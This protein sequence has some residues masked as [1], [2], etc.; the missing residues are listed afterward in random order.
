MRKTCAKEI[1]SGICGETRKLKV[2]S[3]RGSRN[4]LELVMRHRCLESF[5]LVIRYTEFPRRKKSPNGRM[6]E[7]QAG[8]HF[9]LLFP[10]RGVKYFKLWMKVGSLDRGRSWFVGCPGIRFSQRVCL[11]PNLS[12]WPTRCQRTIRGTQQQYFNYR[13]CVA[14]ALIFSESATYGSRRILNYPLSVNIDRMKS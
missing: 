1:F 2:N 8:V 5:L 9:K 13:F 6:L 12:R 10:N 14:A 11:V 7:D 3:D 4:G